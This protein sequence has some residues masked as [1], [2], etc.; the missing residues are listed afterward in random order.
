[1]IDQLILGAL[2]LG[3][4]C[5]GYKAYTSKQK[6][7]AIFAGLNIVKATSH[8]I[9]QSLKGPTFFEFIIYNNSSISHCQSL[10]ID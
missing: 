9:A 8:Q 7:N 6:V 2:G 5:T 3:T 4:V 1:M 10:F